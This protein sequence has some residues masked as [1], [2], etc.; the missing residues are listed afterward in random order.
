MRAATFVVAVASALCMASAGFAAPPLAGAPLQLPAAPQVKLDQ[1][2]G[3]TLP[4]D[5]PVQDEQGRAAHLGDLFGGARAVVVVPGYYRCAQL[6]GLVMQGV[7]E[8]LAGSGLPQDAWRIVGFSF[9]PDDTPATA[10]TREAAYLAYAHDV[11]GLAA[12]APDIHLLTAS[13]AASQALTRAMGYAVQRN[14][15]GDA[16]I[17]HSAGFVVATPDGR[18]ARY[19]PGVRFDAPALRTA[20]VD[21]SGGRIGSLT[22]RL[23]LLCGHY[24]PVS[25]RYSIAVMAWLRG[26]GCALALAL[27]VWMWRHRRV[28]SPRTPPP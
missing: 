17:A 3:G 15:R 19:F 14:S 24:D 12:P 20:L 10:R 7:L 11:A 13:A 22:E 5:T 18:I 8:A 6:C 4:L 28:S 2:L 9:D 1:H 16:A 25:G 27:G 21:A 26:L 23:T